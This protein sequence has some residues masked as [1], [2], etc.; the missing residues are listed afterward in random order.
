[1][2]VI[3]GFIDAVTFALATYWVIRGLKRLLNTQRTVYFILILFYIIFILPVGIDCFITYPSYDTW[4]QFQGFF[5]SY[6]DKLTRIIYDAWMIF[7]Y[8][9]IEK[10][11]SGRLTFRVSNRIIGGGYRSFRKKRYTGREYQ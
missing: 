2:D 11:G 5:V 8:Y 3:V 4:K 7:T 10:I 9:L 6:N 1:M